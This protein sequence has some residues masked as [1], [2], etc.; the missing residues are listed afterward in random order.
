VL[1]RSV[2]AALTTFVL[3]AT[4]QCAAAARTGQLLYVRPLGGNAPP[5][6]GLFVSA[7]D[8]FYGDRDRVDGK[9]ESCR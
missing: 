8:G 7:P 5:D 4:S 3:A 2:P 9:L 1:R 6:P